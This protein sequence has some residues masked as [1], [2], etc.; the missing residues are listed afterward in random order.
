MQACLPGIGSRSDHQR[1]LLWRDRDPRAHAP[2][3]V[4]AILFERAVARQHAIVAGRSGLMPITRCPVRYSAMFATSPSCPTA[5]STSWGSNTKRAR[6]RRSSSDRRQRGGI[7]LSTS[8]S[9]SACLWWRVSRAARSCPRFEEER[10]LGPRAMA[11]SAGDSAFRSETLR[12]ELVA[13]GPC[14]AVH[15]GLQLGPALTPL[16]QSSPGP[17]TPSPQ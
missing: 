2:A 6:L 9:A 16:S 8:C 4:D 3:E 7:A 15:C 1:Q 14:G 10:R 5:T 17:I 12:R 13:Q 11:H